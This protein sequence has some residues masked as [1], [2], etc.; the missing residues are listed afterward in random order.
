MAID[1]FDIARSSYF[2]PHEANAPLIADANAMLTRTVVLQRFKPVAARNAQ[3]TQYPRL[4]Q[5]M[6]FPKGGQLDVEA[7][8]YAYQTRLAPFLDRLG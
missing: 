7:F 8:C 4:V 5:D 3:I 6:K 2:V 1:D